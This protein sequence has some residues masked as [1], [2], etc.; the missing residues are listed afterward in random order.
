MNL[1]ALSVFQQ[2]AVPLLALLFLGTIV[3]VAKGW[4]TRR[5]GL[6]STV[7]WLGAAGAILWPS[8]ASRAAQAVGIGR[9]ADLV[10][11]CAVLAMMIGFWM[12]YIRLRRLRREITLLVRHVALHEAQNVPR[13]PSRSVDGRPDSE[14]APPASDGGIGREVPTTKDTP[15]YDSESDAPD[16]RC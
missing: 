9:G 3:A 8:A 10:F 16:N 15:A 1:L 11:Y 7:V 12:V 13:V 6:V 4:A 5:E 2:I 14:S